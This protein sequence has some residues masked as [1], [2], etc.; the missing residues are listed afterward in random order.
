M[1]CPICKRDTVSFFGTSSYKC[2]SCGI[3]SPDQVVDKPLFHQEIHDT[4][5]EAFAKFYSI[6]NLYGNKNPDL[7]R[8]YYLL[9]AVGVI[10][11]IIIILV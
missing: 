7:S 11:M 2:S 9:I 1:T 10:G 5:D 3:V 6:G 4:A 8:F